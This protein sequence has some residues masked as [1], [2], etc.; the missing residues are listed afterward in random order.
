MKEAPCQVSFRFGNNSTVNGTRAIYFP[1]GSKWIKVVIVPTNTPFLIANSVSET[2]ERRLILPKGK[3][4]F[5]KLAFVFPWNFQSGNCFRSICL[6]FWKIHAAIRVPKWCLVN[7]QVRFCPQGLKRIMMQ[8]ARNHHRV[9][10]HMFRHRLRISCNL[11]SVS[12]KSVFQSVSARRNMAQ[13]PTELDFGDL[14]A[15]LKRLSIKE[16]EDTNVIPSIMAMTW[17]ELQDEKIEFGKAHIGKRYLDMTTETKYMAWFTENYQHSRKPV[18]VK[19][20]R[21][22][23]LWLDNQEKAEP[24]AKSILPKAKAKH[25]PMETHA[26]IELDSDDEVWAQL[27]TENNVE[28]A[29]M[30]S[31]M[32]QME[33]V[34]QE[35]LEHLK[36][37]SQNP[38]AWRST[39]LL[40][41]RSLP[42]SWPTC[43]NHGTTF[44][45][46]SL[47]MRRIELGITM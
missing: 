31:R 45:M 12:H 21:F 43:V 6:I 37:T 5:K 2:W 38:T 44:F 15:R 8:L 32:G 7:A 23:Q 42:W 20:M 3:C 18:H 36:R 29:E 22:I 4:C 16:S 24:A 10:N 34:L 46:L 13:T 19:F 1:V 17:K 25:P 33:I 30:R 41:I 39:R 26:P 11:G 47:T 28:M 14:T 9:Q 35:V 27:S 40:N